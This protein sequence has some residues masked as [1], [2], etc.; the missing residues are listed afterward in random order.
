MIS[1]L[2]HTVPPTI[3]TWSQ[4]LFLAIS[5]GCTQFFIFQKSCSWMTYRNAF[6]GDL[7]EHAPEQAF[8]TSSGTVFESQV[9]SYWYYFK[10]KFFINFVTN[11][12]S[13][14]H[15]LEGG[16]VKCLLFHT[17]P[18]TIT[19]QSQNSFFDFSWACRQ[20]FIFQNRIPGNIPGMRSWMT[21]RNAFLGDIQEHAPE[22]AFGTFS[23]TVPKCQVLL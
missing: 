11:N 1:L 20:F 10:C 12:F 15:L 6:L 22:L 16:G 4:N 14:K 23:G 3:K 2:F 8:G 7:Q 18:P 9:L 19:T 21:Y 5:E 13:L 17:V